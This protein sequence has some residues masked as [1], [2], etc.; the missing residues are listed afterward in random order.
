MHHGVNRLFGPVFGHRRFRPI[1]AVTM[2]VSIARSEISRHWGAAMN[3]LH[4]RDSTGDR[5]PQSQH[6]TDSDAAT[7]RR[8][9]DAGKSSDRAEESVLGIIA[10]VEAQLNRI[11]AAQG[12]HTEE[13]VSLESRA[14]TLDQRE[15]ALRDRTAELAES[16]AM[17]QSLQGD[18][19]QARAE[20][21]KQSRGVDQRASQIEERES[22]LN[23][24]TRGME[25]R[26]KTLEER[27]GLLEREMEELA[28]AR[29]LLD[30]HWEE[31]NAERERLSE[32]AEEIET[33]KGRLATELEEAKN[34]LARTTAELKSFTETQARTEEERDRA[35]SDLQAQC[36]RTEQAE[37]NVGEL[38]EKV[39]K[40]MRSI[41][42]QSARCEI[43][44]TS[45]KELEDSVA[46]L[47]K[48]LDDAGQAFL[49]K[50]N[51][52][53]AAQQRVSEFEQ[54]VTELEGQVK[55][56]FA[57]VEQ[58]DAERHELAERAEHERDELQAA[59]AE[60]TRKQEA[61]ERQVAAL[62]KE[63]ESGQEIIN[64]QKGTLKSAKEK[65][66][67]FAKSIGE[68]TE[69]IKHGA[70]AIAT[71]R[72]QRQQI[73]RLKDQLTKA[74]LSGNP[75]ELMR[76]EQRIG[77]LTDAL[78]QARG[79]TMGDDDIA[80][81]DKKIETLQKERDDLRVEL[82]RTRVEA[83]DAHQDAE[84]HRA[85]GSDRRE[86]EIVG[87]N[88]RIRELEADLAQKETELADGSG[89]DQEQV[90][91]MSKRIAEL[92]GA[93]AEAE[94]RVPSEAETAE[95][96]AQ[97]ERKTTKIRVVAQHLRRRRQRLARV[98]QLL[99]ERPRRDEPAA[100]APKRTPD[101][102]EEQMRISARL[103]REYQALREAART[104]AKSEKKMIRKWARPRAVVTMTWF[105]IL[106][107]LLA[108][109][110]WFAADHL[111]PAT[112][113]A[114]VTV[115]AAAGPGGKLTNEQRAAW[116]TWHQNR[117][118]DE[119][120]LRAAAKRFDDRRFT[121]LND[122]ALLRK[123]LKQSLTLDSR[124]DGQLMM[125]MI[126]TDPD[127]LRMIL[128]TLA[129]TLVAESRRREGDRTDGAR[130]TIA[131]ARNTSAGMQYAAIADLPIND[132][133]TIWMGYI[134]G[135]SFPFAIILIWFISRR[136]THAKRIFD[137]DV[138][139]ASD[140]RRIN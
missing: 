62:Q 24:Y 14:R 80:E 135:G 73:D 114:T 117:L 25:E 47:Q 132:E 50:S 72:E 84:A 77:E 23:E 111:K 48:R 131:N 39:E 75:D 101:Q 97:F 12:E 92:E 79:Q 15:Q 53:E 41:G 104:L 52:H 38:I 78:R 70:E 94:G 19:Q 95:M 66:G 71:V 16:E 119:T 56:A 106:A 134:F 107:A 27:L 9:Q 85:E 99:R 45:E 86:A 29:R 61:S 100:P 124:R 76:K 3:D 109:G 139:L 59:L 58:T 89:D 91:E 64:N 33:G 82:E 6:N 37:R 130:T 115:Q 129:V 127:R 36:R 30:Q 17:V 123:Y 138:V 20:V 108:V 43:L 42:E 57:K 69:Q 60:A 28:K 68:Q 118:G 126:G 83:Q 54:R 96:K 49:E 98:R 121:E 51:E 63:A 74:Q 4:D 46:D 133:R 21:E 87:L 140:H 55:K 88:A 116:Q 103:Q 13:L 32:Q 105:A 7:A 11:R 18:L 93:L 65:L 34:E 112:V 122:S 67:E 125:S 10:D 31:F 136:L 110:S 8:E 35:S 120:F 2:S 113:A 22:A 128:D 102:A 40:G 5:S 44:T 137:A 1:A 81:R 90:T 26:K